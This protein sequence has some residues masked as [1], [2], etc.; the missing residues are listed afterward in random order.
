MKRAFI[1]LVAVA[2]LI[3]GYST[4]VYAAKKK[5]VEAEIQ[6]GIS[7]VTQKKKQEKEYAKGLFEK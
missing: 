2:I 4:K 6:K 1:V 7:G 3:G 5:S